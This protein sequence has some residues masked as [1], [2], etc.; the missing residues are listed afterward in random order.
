MALTS[1]GFLNLTSSHSSRELRKR[2]CQRLS[3]LSSD[4]DVVTF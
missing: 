1:T 4:N 2:V 3:M